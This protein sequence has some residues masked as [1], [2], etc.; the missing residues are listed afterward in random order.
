ML[1][2]TKSIKENDIILVY[3]ENEPSFFA[4]AEKIYPDVKP[5]WWRVKLLILQIPVFVT[6]WILDNDQI[7]GA[8]FTMNGT[9]VRIEKV[10]TPPDPEMD[11]TSVENEKKHQ[12]S[13]NK[14][15]RILSF[16]NNRTT[17]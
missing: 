2:K 17:N 6:T 7:R 5:N 14:S 15:A 1:S 3:V 13:S 10:N 12:K 16:N 9:P 4:R 11:N 8:E